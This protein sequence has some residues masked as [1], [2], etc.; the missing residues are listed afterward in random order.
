MDYTITLTDTELSSLLDALDY[1]YDDRMECAKIANVS[2]YYTE[3]DVQE[4]EAAAEAYSNI[5][6]KIIDQRR[7]QDEKKNNFPAG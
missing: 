1:A 6:D 5:M 3:E 4:Q 7:Y 2:N